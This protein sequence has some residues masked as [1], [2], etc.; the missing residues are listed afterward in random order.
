MY[1]SAS[2]AEAEDSASIVNEFRP[3]KTMRH[4]HV[5]ALQPL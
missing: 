5:L 1:K 3:Q 2:L 4:I